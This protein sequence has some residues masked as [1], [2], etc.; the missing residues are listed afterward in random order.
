MAGQPERS[1][2]T[3]GRDADRCTPIDRW[4]LARLNAAG[5]R[6]DRRRSSDYDIHAPAKAIEGFVEEL[7]NWYV[8]RNRRRF[9][10]AEDDADKQ[11]AYQ[12]LYTCLTTLARLLAPFMPFVSEAMYRN[13]VGVGS[14]D[15]GSGRPCDNANS[16]L[17]TPSRRERAPGRLAGVRRSADRRCSCCADTA[18]LLETISLGRAAR[19]SAELKVRQPLGALVAARARLDR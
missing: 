9:W 16:Q 6:R 19:R 5:A 10:K 14:R 8:R 2:V 3:V 13:L 12:T 17:P 7:S 1:R 4:A 18:L 11:A 15:W